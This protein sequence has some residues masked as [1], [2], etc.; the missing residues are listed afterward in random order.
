MQVLLFLCVG[1]SL[2]HLGVQQNSYL[3]LHAPR[4]LPQQNSR[5]YV[6]I[7]LEFH[8]ALLGSLYEELDNPDSAF[9]SADEVVIFLSSNRLPANGNIKVTATDFNNPS[10]AKT[11]INNF[12][13]LYTSGKIKNF[14]SDFTKDTDAVLI[15]CADKWKVP[16]SGGRDFLVQLKGEYNV[17]VN[18]EL[19]F[20]MVEIPKNQYITALYILPDIGKEEAVGAAINQTNLA[21]WRNSLTQQ[22]VTL[23]VPRAT[24]YGCAALTAENIDIGFQYTRKK[25]AS[26][27]AATFP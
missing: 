20:T 15:S 19:G 22:L 14:F 27:I 3:T 26:R 25:Y 11:Q 5:D 16:V 21:L 13:T 1:A 8:S 2:V 7:S 18:K 6:L 12:L 10:E 17:L 23:E 4:H 9:Q 24:L